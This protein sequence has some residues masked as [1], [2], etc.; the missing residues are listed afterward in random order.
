[1]RPP[2][3]TDGAMRTALLALLALSGCATLHV[4]T[5]DAEAHTELITAAGDIA[6]VR[7]RVVAEPAKGVL[8]VEVRDNEGDVCG[9]ALERL[10]HADGVGDA[11]ANGI[12]DCEPRAWSCN[13][14]ALLAHEIGHVIGLLGHTTGGLMDPAPELDAELSEWE[15][16]R[17]QAMAV[18]FVEICR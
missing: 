8:T 15:K 18:V 13:H 10:V 4:Y 11:L 9:R 16:R 6:G 5:E 14:P 17:I 7:T 12:F 3:Y 1:M 2:Y